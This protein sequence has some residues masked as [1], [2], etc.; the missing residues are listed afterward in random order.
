MKPICSLRRFFSCVRARLEP[1]AAY[2]KRRGGCCG[3]ERAGLGFAVMESFMDRVRVRSRL[4]AGTTVTLE[5][6]I[7]GKGAEKGE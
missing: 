7:R 1:A 2:G 3:E 4:G 6:Q 5:K